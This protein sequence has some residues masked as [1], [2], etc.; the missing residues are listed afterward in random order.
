MKLRTCSQS[1]VAQH[2]SEHT[3][4]C[5]KGYAVR[6]I[7]KDIHFPRIFSCFLFVPYKLFLPYLIDK[8]KGGTPGLL[9]E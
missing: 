7:K 5:K 4:F 2:E 8:G 6:Q 9:T 1:I 3:A